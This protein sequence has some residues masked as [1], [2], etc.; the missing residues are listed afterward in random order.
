MTENFKQAVEVG[1]AMGAITTPWWWADFAALVNI[2]VPPVVGV[3]GLIVLI[4]TAVEKIKDIRRRDRGFGAE[5]MAMDAN[6]SEG[7]P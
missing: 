5:Q 2:W 4:L 7:E 3:L 1:T 6:E